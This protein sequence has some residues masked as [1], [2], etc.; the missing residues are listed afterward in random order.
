MMTTGGGNV[1][2]CGKLEAPKRTTPREAE[3]CDASGDRILALVCVLLAKECQDAAVASAWSAFRVLDVG[4]RHEGDA[5]GQDQEGCAQEGR[6]DVKIT[7]SAARGWCRELG[8]CG[9]R[10]ELIWGLFL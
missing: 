8:H 1:K 4:H 7:A 2:A 3:R 5:H 9:G 6:V 10:S